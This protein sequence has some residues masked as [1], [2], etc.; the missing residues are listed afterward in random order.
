M[1]KSSILTHFLLLLANNTSGKFLSDKDSY[2]CDRNLVQ[3]LVY[4]AKITEWFS[5]NS[6]VGLTEKGQVFLSRFKLK[7]HVFLT[8][9]LKIF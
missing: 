4:D 8:A 6:T 1:F 3:S 9:L 5:R 2:Y 7:L